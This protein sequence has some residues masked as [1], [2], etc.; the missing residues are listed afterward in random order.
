MKS[1]KVIIIFFLVSANFACVKENIRGVQTSHKPDRTYGLFMKIEGCGPVLTWQPVL[2]ESVTYDLAVFNVLKSPRKRMAL[3]ERG[4]QIFYVE[5]ISGSSVKV[6]PPLQPTKDYYWSV[7]KRY[8]DGRVSEW[9]TYNKEIK[10]W[11]AGDTRYSNF[12][13]GITTPQS[14]EGTEND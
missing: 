10:N 2:E 3:P 11:W 1:I 7:R 9:S 5:N 6:D 4:A 12:W 14:C 13:F 8:P